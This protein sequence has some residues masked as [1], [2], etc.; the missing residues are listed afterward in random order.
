MAPKSSFFLFCLVIPLA[1]AAC[2]TKA[3]ASPTADQKMVAT[4]VAATLQAATNATQRTLPTHLPTQIPPPTAQPTVPEPTSPPSPTSAPLPTTVVPLVPDTLVAYT[5]N[6][7]VYIWTLKDGPTRLTDLHDVVSVRLTDDGT[8]V[9]FK[10]QDSNDTTLQELWMVNT[11]GVPVPQVLVSTDELAALVPP[12]A[13]SSVLGYG[14]LDFTWHPGTHELAYG[15]LIL[16][17]GPGFSPNH[18]LRLVNADTM[19]K[20][21][22]FD[23]GQGGLFYYSP[24][25]SQVALSNPQSLSLVNADGSNLRRDVLTFPY[26]ITYSEYEYH[27]HPI[28]AGDSGSIGIAIPP[29]DPLN[30]P[31]P[32]TQVWL[33]PLDGSQPTLM[34]SIPAIPFAWP[35]TAI[36]PDLQLAGYSTDVAGANPNQRALHIARLDGTNDRFYD[37]GESLEFISWA[38]DAMHFMYRVQGG[39]NEGLYAGGLT[40]MPVKLVADPHTVREIQWWDGTR[41]VYLVN[42]NDRWELHFGNVSGEDLALIDTIPDASPAFD[43]KP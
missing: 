39:A 37:S 14:V 24:D 29:H 41:F 15:T 1:L 13:G 23:T 27:P 36:S 11:S 9:A 42:K 32:L 20:T 28:W 26:V 25:G 31:A 30:D 3:Q 19:L 6:S 18:D 5:K 12:D 4:A 33:I 16:H 43:V 40:E 38:P 34:I 10:R 8:L 2:G 7:D 22:L 35:D 21:T 17:E